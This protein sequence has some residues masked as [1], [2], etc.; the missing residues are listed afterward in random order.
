MIRREKFY[1]VEREL[2]LNAIND[3][4]E[5]QGGSGTYSDPKTGRAGFRVALG[6][7]EYEYR[8][9]VTDAGEGCEV[10]LEMAEIVRDAIVDRA[11][12]LLESILPKGGG[13]E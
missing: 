5:L 10:A 7:R 11:F 3:L 2:I 6:E 12:F 4:A 13:A 1:P 9:A 8:F